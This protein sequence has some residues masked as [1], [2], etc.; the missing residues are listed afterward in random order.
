MLSKERKGKLF[1]VSAPSGAGKTTLCRSVLAK[2]SQI[3][4]SISYTT[5]PPR[6]GETHGKDYHFVSQK[7][8]KEMI[9]EQA[10]SEW[11][12]VHGH[13]Y[14]T[15]K[16]LIENKMKNGIDVL[17]SIDVQGADQLR[18]LYPDAVSIFVNPP[19]LEELK[20]RL[21]E[22]KSDSEITIQKRLEVAQREIGAGASYEFCIVNDDFE[23]A[24]QEL[25]S[26]IEAQR[27]HS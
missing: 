16:S 18:K 27:Q 21:I 20:K 11:A 15:S 23:K 5:R 13:Q 14:G 6:V 8:F 9:G 22:R 2:L 17:L 19:S 7:K 25:I 26:I 10:F 4:P 3:E 1:I 24:L 12:V